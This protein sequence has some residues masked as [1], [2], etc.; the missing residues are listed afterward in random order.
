MGISSLRRMEDRTS[1]ISL[2]HRRR[3]RGDGGDVSPPRIFLGGIVPPSIFES[4]KNIFSYICILNS[5]KVI[6]KRLIQHKNTTKHTK[7]LNLPRAS[8]ADSRPNHISASL[9]LPAISVA[10]EGGGQGGNSP[11]PPPIMLFQSYVG[12]FRNLSLHVSR[13]ACH[14]Y[15]QSIWGT[16]KISK[17]IAILECKNARKIF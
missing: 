13:Q 16:N 12:I 4:L 5:M 8:R 9:A 7:S 6:Q 15:R 14:L 2:N 3:S 10:G 11:P 17:E 1:H